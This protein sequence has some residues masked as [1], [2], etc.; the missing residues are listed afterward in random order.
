M[1]D[2]VIVAGKRTPM[3]EYGGELK[4]FT[5]LELGAFAAKAAINQ[6]KLDAGDFDHCIS[7]MR[8]KQA[9]T[10]YTV[11]AMLAFVRGFRLRFLH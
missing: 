11:L 9:A 2:I 4:D 8:F 6:S 5:A 1:K 10:P 7:G 3:G